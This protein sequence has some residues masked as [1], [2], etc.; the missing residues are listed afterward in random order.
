MVRVITRLQAQNDLD[1]IDQFGIAQFGVEVSDRYMR[2][3]FDAFDQLAN[4]PEIGP[5][6]PGIR[7]SIRF[8]THRSHHIFYDFDGKIVTV[9]RILHHAMNASRALAQLQ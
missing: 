4:F 9:V 3:F 1:D 8:L 5:I 2:G 7:P 6:Y